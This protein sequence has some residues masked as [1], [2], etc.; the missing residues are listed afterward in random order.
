MVD[1][2]AGILVVDCV[3]N[4]IIQIASGERGIWWRWDASWWWERGG[5]FVE[6][7]CVATSCCSFCYVG[8]ECLVE[9]DNILVVL[10]RGN[11]DSY[12][13]QKGSLIVGRCLPVVMVSSLLIEGS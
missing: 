13:S 12:S 6:E 10:E 3:I 11:H 7:I 8:H 2:E 5:I 4:V 9:V 1:V